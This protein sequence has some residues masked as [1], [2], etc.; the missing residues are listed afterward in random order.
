ML[1]GFNV[2]SQYHGSLNT[3]KPQ[4]K[5]DLTYLNYSEVQSC[6]VG[7]DQATL[8][9]HRKTCTYHAVA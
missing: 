9:Q 8:V 3:V 7:S 1:R 4:I 2:P 6:S 5:S